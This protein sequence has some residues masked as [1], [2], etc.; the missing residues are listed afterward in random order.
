MATHGGWTMATKARK[1]PYC[2]E[3]VTAKA[4]KC[5]HCGAELTEVPE[6]LN[7]AVPRSANML[8]LLIGLLVVIA[9]AAAVYM[10]VIR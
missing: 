10:V 9:I 4:T 1:C 2:G 5:K 3:K 6:T 7:Q 8:P